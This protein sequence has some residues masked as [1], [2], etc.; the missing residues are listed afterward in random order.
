M[1]RGNLS[2]RNMQRREFMALL[3][4]AAAAASLSLPATAQQPAMPVIGFL[5]SASPGPFAHLIAGFRHGLSESGYVEN[6]NYL[7]EYRWAEGHYDRLS[8]LATEL[9]AKRVAVIVATGGEAVAL[10]AKA[11]TETIPI[12]FAGGGDPVR[13]GL[14]ASLN[15]PGANVTGFNQLTYELEPKRVGLLH[16]LVPAADRIALLVN[17]NNPATPTALKEVQEAATSVGVKLTAVAVGDEK[18]FDSAFARF[19]REG[20]GALLVSADPYFNTRRAQLVAL[21]ARHHLPAIYEFREF[22]LAGGLMSY[23]SNLAN[24]FRQVGDYTGRILKGTKPAELPVLQPTV[25]ELVINVGTAKA[26]GFPI[27]PTLLARADEVI[28]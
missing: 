16:E 14:V 5:N 7:I 15:R 18:E 25:F 19:M 12:V 28:E 1:A 13:A 2:K 9:V 22:A 3:G 10:A 11:A 17:A 6:Q 20:A 8:S 23:G 26:L 4:G 21:A 24:A 27:P